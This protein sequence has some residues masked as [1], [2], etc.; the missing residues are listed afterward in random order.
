MGSGHGS[1]ES[2]WP[3]GSRAPGGDGSV[4]RGA[5]GQWVTAAGTKGKSR[6]WIRT[7][8]GPGS[9]GTWKE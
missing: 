1:A 5:L 6:Y 9:D 3:A 4:G 7:R 2:P 8:D